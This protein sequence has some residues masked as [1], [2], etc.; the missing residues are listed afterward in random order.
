MKVYLRNMN[1]RLVVKEM[2][3][4]FSPYMRTGT[5]S[6]GKTER[7]QKCNECTSGNVRECEDLKVEKRRE[8]RLALL[9]NL[10]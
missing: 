8:T 3:H 10:R 5:W 1:S 6:T 4:C 9:L 2:K 7:P